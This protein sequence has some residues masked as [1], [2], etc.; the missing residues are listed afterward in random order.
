[1]QN[2]PKRTAAVK[3]PTPDVVYVQPGPFNKYRFLLHLATIVAVVIALLFG[4]SIFFKVD[5]VMVTGFQKYTAWDIRDTLTGAF[6]DERGWF[7]FMN[8][9]RRTV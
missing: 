1:V 4:M 9:I 8:T 3:K 6:R 2:R 7:G 5:T